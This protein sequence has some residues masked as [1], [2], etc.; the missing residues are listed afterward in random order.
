MNCAIDH[1]VITAPSLAAGTRMLHEALGIWPQLG[2]EH[3]R[4]GTHNTLLRLGEKLYLE[5]I[6]IDPAVAKPNRPRW[7]RLG[8]LTAQST[9]RLATWVARCADIHAA[10]A[11]CG[12]IHGE[13]A[14]MSRGD[15]NWLI[16]IPEDGGMPFD[17]VAPS[18]IQWQ[19]PQHP[20][21][22][23]ED[24]GCSLVSLKGFHPDAAR[25][26]DLLR[27]LGCASEIYVEEDQRAHLVAEIQ[28]PRGLRTLGA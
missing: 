3:A 15:L 27:H 17:G 22:R 28:T 5:V 26:N 19:S 8:E 4:M 2:G 12:G 16:S 25:I 1:L 6:A 9:P 18:L 10:H 13:I 11:A 24:R 23:L 20:A 21:N 7:F 14:T